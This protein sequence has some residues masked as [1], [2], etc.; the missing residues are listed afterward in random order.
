MRAAVLHELGG[1]PA[2]EE[3]GDPSGDEDGEIVDV[4]IAGLNPV[5]VTIAAGNM[6]RVKPE[7]PYVVGLEG[8]G[9]LAGSGRRAY[10]SGTVAPFG[11]FAERTVAVADTLI[12]VP[13]G[14]GDAQAVAFGI[15]GMAGWI[16]LEWRAGLRQGES[17]L[18]LGASGVVGQIAIQAARLLGAGRV[19]AA[20]RDEDSLGR[21]AQLGADDTVAIPEDP[22]D[23]TQALLEV[24]GGGVDLIVDPVWGPAAVAALGAVAKDGRLVQIGNAASPTAEIPAGGLRNKHATILGYTNFNVP[25]EI[26]ADAFRRMCEH[27]ARGDLWVEVEDVPLSEVAD[28]W[29]RQQGGPHHKLA[30]RP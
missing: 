10:F 12:D 2:A 25:Q 9:T 8:I 5:D 16:A 21:L 26:K 22:A 28:A 30:I 11:S 4:T 13:D 29:E 1:T 18:V 3:F 23:F 27:A 20:A 24:S 15:A 19:I 7:V 14:V 17:V 6:P